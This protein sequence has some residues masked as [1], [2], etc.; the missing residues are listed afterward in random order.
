[1]GV[2]V[3]GEVRAFGFDRRVYLPLGEWRSIRL[4]AG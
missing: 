2:G 4:R 3:E 1:M